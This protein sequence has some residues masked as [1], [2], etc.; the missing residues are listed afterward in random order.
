MKLI[1]IEPGRYRFVKPTTP[2]ARSHL[3][4]PYVISDVMP[5]TEQVDGRFYESKAAF[6]AA[7]KALGLVEVGNEKPKP[8]IRASLDPAFRQGRKKQIKTAIEKVRA[9]H[10][11][12][13]FHRD[14]TRRAAAG[15]SADGSNDT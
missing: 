6:R 8:K 9:G 2:P 12:R 7:G 5:P 11:E 10:Y 14:G 4:L 1:E 15:G 13:H 3:P